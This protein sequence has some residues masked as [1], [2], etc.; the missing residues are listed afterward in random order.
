MDSA[1][2]SAKDSAMDS[3]MDSAI[4]T[5][6][7]KF[8]SPAPEADGRNINCPTKVNDCFEICLHGLRI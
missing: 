6:E 1:K 8:V 3:A 7:W 2:D 4:N 5:M